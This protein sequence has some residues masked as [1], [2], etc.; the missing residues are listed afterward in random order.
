[1][2]RGGGGAPSRRGS[3]GSTCCSGE[4]DWIADE[5]GELQRPYKHLK[6][7]EHKGTADCLL[8]KKGNSLKRSRRWSQEENGN[9][10]QMVNLHSSKSWSTV[11]RGIPGR[12]PNQCRD[13]WMFYLD[14]SVNNQPWSEHEDIKLIQAHKIH[15]SKW[16]KLAKLFPG[17]TGK[18]VKNHWPSLL[19]KQMKSDLVSGL[20]EQFPYIPKDPSVTKSK[21]SSTF[22][23]DQ[24]SSINIHV[25]SDSAVRPKPEQGIAE[26]GRNESTLKGTSYDS[27]HGNGS[28][29]HSV[30]V[31]EKVDGQIFRSN[32]LS[33][34]DQK[35]SSATGSFP[36][37]LPK[38]ES[39]NFLEVTPNR[40]LC[41]T[42]DHL[43][44][45]CFDGICS[46]A[47]RESQELHLSSIAYL[48]DMPYC[49][50][51]MI[52]PPDSP[53]HGNYA[54]GM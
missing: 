28:V 17:R 8:H 2:R 33:C 25:S 19:R 47:D 6:D 44:N 27:V 4:I 10:I 43:S 9:L 51:L 45:D 5:R 39:T 3:G 46:S 21:G 48:L 49:K 12:S 54:D 14:P 41:T 24:D 22:Q 7:E 26:N 42:Y 30:N 11:A 53:D 34:M 13:R 31:S 38:E 37:S 29:S 1:M 23:S 50:S 20:P 36:G 32:S 35:A 52:V 18:A 40:G 16:S 15:G